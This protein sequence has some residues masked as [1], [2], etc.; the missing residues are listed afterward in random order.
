MGHL[1]GG[2]PPGDGAPYD[3]GDQVRRWA[4]SAGDG[5]QRNVC[6]HSG[7]RGADLPLW[8]V[9]PHSG[10]DRP[11]RGCE[12]AGLPL[13]RPDAP[14]RRAGSAGAGGGAVV[15]LMKLYRRYEALLLGSIGLVG[16]MVIW[17]T[18]ARLQ[19]MAPLLIS[20]PTQVA[21]ALERWVLSGVLWRDLGTSLGEL[22]IAFTA[23]AV[24]GIP[25]GVIMGGRRP[26]GY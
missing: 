26:V 2:A 22:L 16:L 21:L 4:R 20:S 8:K 6:F 19:W 25:V 12:P 13:R 17:E 10:V 18:A 24:I 1:Q 5:R 7:D 11:D 9:F 23:A 14:D 3:D 15:R